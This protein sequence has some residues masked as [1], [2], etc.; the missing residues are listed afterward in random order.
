MLDR[1]ALF[2]VLLAPCLGVL[3][4]LLAWKAERLPVPAFLAG[5]GATGA[6]LGVVVLR[7]V[8]L[9]NLREAPLVGVAWGLL[10][11]LGFAAAG[12]VA[13]AAW[14]ATTQGVLSWLARRRGPR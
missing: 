7:D 9:A 4:A 13:A 6:I 1:A 12:V 11:S 8:L 2:C 10:L 3:H 14:A 5:G